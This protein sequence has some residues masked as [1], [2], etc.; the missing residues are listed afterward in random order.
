M[1]D[2]PEEP[3]WAEATKKVLV[4]V[5]RIATVFVVNSLDQDITV[6]IKGMRTEEYSSVVDVGP[7]FTVASESVDARTLTPETSGWLPYITVELQCS[8]APSSGSV[9]VYL[10]K[11]QGYEEVL[12]DALEIRDSNVHNPSTDSEI[13]ILEW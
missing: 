5:L 11:S 7:S 3:L 2:V 9:T 12:V 1:S 13:S 4:E 10:I 6:Q 8:S